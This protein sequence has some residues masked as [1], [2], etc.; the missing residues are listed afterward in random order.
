M[1]KNETTKSY[2]LQFDSNVKFLD[3]KR[4]ISKLVDL[5]VYEQEWWFRSNIN[6]IELN[7]TSLEKMI[8]S[9]QVLSLPLTV[10]IKNDSTL[11][12]IKEIHD[13]LTDS[14]TKI[15][16]SNSTTIHFN[17][18]TVN[19]NLSNSKLTPEVIA[20]ATST[21]QFTFK[22]SFLVTHKTSTTNTK[23]SNKMSAAQLACS[24]ALDEE[25]VEEDYFNDD[26]IVQPF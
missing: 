26:P 9:G 12:E 20:G 10:L 3:L 23:T 25:Q 17:N 4:K 7:E 16:A 6:S 1:K 22:L 15:A 24:S 5:N 18:S 11:N 13:N 2:R 14:N 19:V 8:E 21:T